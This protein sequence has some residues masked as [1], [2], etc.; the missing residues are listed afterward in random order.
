MANPQERHSA[1]TSK[2]AA[3]SVTD[4]VHNENRDCHAGEIKV[5]VGAQGA[6]CVTYEPEKPRARP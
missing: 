6:V 4:C 2:V 3:C 5:E 1:Q